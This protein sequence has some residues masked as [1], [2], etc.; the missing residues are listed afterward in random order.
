VRCWWYDALCG[1]GGTLCY[2]GVWVYLGSLP[3]VGE[4]VLQRF[5]MLDA[6][7]DVLDRLGGVGEGFDLGDVLLVEVVERLHHVTN[8]TT[9]HKTPPTQEYNLR[10]TQ[11]KGSQ[12]N[13]TNTT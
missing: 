11:K 4:L 1:V 7:T 13:T 12:K 5:Q 8:T 9:K 10:N 3:I 2:D 6:Q